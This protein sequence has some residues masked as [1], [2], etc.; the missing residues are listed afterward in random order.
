M[1][2]ENTE[3]RRKEGQP[4]VYLLGEVCLSYIGC[5]SLGSGL[6]GLPEA[7]GFCLLTFPGGPALPYCRESPCNTVRVPGAKHLL[8]A[9]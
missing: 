3:Q 8:I 5:S 9:P 4:K 7:A 2:F 6:F 1:L